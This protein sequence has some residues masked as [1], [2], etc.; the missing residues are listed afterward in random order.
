MMTTLLNRLNKRQT[1]IAGLLLIVLIILIWQLYGLFAGNDNVVPAK[2]NKNVARVVAQNADQNVGQVV[3]QQLPDKIAPTPG[4]TT[5][6]DPTTNSQAEYLRLVNE[7]QMAQLQRMIAEDNEA[8]AVAK[9]NA[10]Q[11]MSDTVGM[12][13]GSIADDSAN[14]QAPS[15]VYSLVYTG[16]QN[17]GQWT[18]TLKKDGQTSDVVSG[19]QLPD[20]A[21]VMSIDENGV[22]LNQANNAG[23]LLVTFS[24]VTPVNNIT[25]PVVSQA[26]AQQLPDNNVRERSAHPD[27]QAK[28]APIVV[29]KPVTKPV[30][31]AA[32]PVVTPVIPV[33]KPVVVPQPKASTTKTVKPVVDQLAAQQLPDNKDFYTIQLTSDNELASVQGFIA[34]HK[35]QDKATYVP[36]KNKH[37][38]TWYVGI[39]GQYSTRAAAQQALEALPASVR[40]EGAYVVSYASIH[41][42][43]K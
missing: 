30:V 24:G 28:S 6:V 26:V 27:L 21:Q 38:T 11:A 9:R 8:I 2:A 12:A 37:G 39:Y 25:K 32:K 10:A 40:S 23:K 33:S 35:L 5:A 31:V 16:Q 17:D 4:A 41:A 13:G 29:N 22:L 43:A 20:G 36:A 34:D 7:Y 1:V 18:A 14:N 3:A 19:Q 42:Q 15:N